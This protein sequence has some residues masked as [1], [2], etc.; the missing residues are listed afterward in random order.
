MGNKAFISA[1][2]TGGKELERNLLQLGK[3]SLVKNTIRAA[4]RKALRPV[5]DRASQ[6][7]P[8]DWGTLADSINVRTVSVSS[9]AQRGTLT[10]GVGPTKGG[11]YGMFHEFGW[12]LAGGSRQISAKPFL[13]PAWDEGRAA[14]LKDFGAELW[15]AIAKTAK[16]LARQ[17]RKAKQ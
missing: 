14:V 2:F 4:Q 13:R 3:L 1:E 10:M 11:F 12:R 15:K 16:R 6:L 5:A 17:A 8:R 9:G 7:A